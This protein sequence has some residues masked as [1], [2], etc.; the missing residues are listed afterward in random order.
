MKVVM[1]KRSVR[2]EN[3]LVLLANLGVKRNDNGV[4]NVPQGQEG[5]EGSD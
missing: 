1:Q 5:T 3:D 4:L 2:A